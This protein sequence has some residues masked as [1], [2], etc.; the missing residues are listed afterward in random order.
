M[1]VLVEASANDWRV[2]TIAFGGGCIQ[3]TQLLVP[4]PKLQTSIYTP[5]IMLSILENIILLALETVK[6]A[7]E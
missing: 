1:P 5:S 6:Y 4:F 3:I 7:V 2:K